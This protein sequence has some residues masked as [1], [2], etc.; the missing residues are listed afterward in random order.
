MKYPMTGIDLIGLADIV[1]ISIKFALFM[2]E[3]K[4]R[5]VNMSVTGVRKITN[6]YDEVFFLVKF[7]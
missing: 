1:K 7:V 2:R 5:I 6:G 4:K 3:R